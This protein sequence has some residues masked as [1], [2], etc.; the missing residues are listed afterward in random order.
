ME[1]EM[2]KHSE[3]LQRCDNR[4]WDGRCRAILLKALG[5]GYAGKAVTGQYTASADGEDLMLCHLLADN[6]LME[7][8]PTRNRPTLFLVTEAGAAAVG[9]ELDEEDAL[10]LK[11]INAI[12]G[13]AGSPYGQWRIALRDAHLAKQS[14]PL[15]PVN[16]DIVRHYPEAAWIASLSSDPVPVFH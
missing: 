10:Y 12:P 7:F 13:V 2:G 9:C 6:G 3:I 1:D 4:V 15:A 11:A 16:D 14:M 5:Y 8:H